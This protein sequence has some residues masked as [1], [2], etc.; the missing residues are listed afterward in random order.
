MEATRLASVSVT[1][2]GG[3]WSVPA[4]CSSERSVHCDGLDMG[5]PST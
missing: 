2:M 1:K 5:V 4:V 3:L